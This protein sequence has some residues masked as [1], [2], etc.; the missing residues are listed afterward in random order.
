M[1]C[2]LEGRPTE[3]TDASGPP[4]PS[5]GAEAP[6][7]TSFRKTTTRSRSAGA[8]S[9]R[10]EPTAVGVVGDSGGSTQ[11]STALPT[12]AGDAGS[13]YSPTSTQGTPRR[14]DTLGTRFERLDTGCRSSELSPSSSSNTA[15]LSDGRAFKAR[16][17]RTAASTAGGTGPHTSGDNSP[18]TSKGTGDAA[19]R[20]GA[21]RDGRDGAAGAGT[22]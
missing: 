15:E 22:S 19:C 1:A 3:D 13:T 11:P 2:T 12:L 6:W 4:P 16:P 10:G 9:H 18:W 21:D 5:S 20:E 7:R 14:V 8:T 17:L